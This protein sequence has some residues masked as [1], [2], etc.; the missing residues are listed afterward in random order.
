L[1]G[2]DFAKR[3]TRRRHALQAVIVDNQHVYYEICEENKGEK[4]ERN[5]LESF[6]VDDL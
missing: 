4:S 6:D 2:E 1:S 5:H 3:Y